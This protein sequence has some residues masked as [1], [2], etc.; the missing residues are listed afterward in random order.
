MKSKG[1]SKPKKDGPIASS[2]TWVVPP[3]LL[4]VSLFFLAQFKK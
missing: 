3:M 4:S 1:K 2:E